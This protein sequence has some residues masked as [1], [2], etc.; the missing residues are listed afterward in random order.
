MELTGDPKWENILHFQYVFGENN[1]SCPA[2]DFSYIVY[3]STLFLNAQNIAKTWFC[4]NEELISCC[5]FVRD[6][7]IIHIVITFFMASTVTHEIAF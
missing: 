1:L 2:L 7:D 5:N 6:L 4:T 3:K